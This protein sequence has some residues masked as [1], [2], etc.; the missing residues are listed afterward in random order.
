MTCNSKDRSWPA[1]WGRWSCSS[2]LRW[3]GLTWT[4][5]SRCGVLSTGE[6][7]LLEHVQ[8]RATKMTQGM[9]HLPYENR[10]RELGLFS[11]QKRRVQGGLRAAFQYLKGSCK[12]EG[13]RL[14]SRVC[15]DRA[16]GNT[17]RLKFREIL[18]WIKGRNVL[19]YG[20]WG[21]RSGC[22]ERWWMPH[23]WRNSGSG[24]TGLW[25]TW[26]CC[27]CPC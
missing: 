3:W 1:S 27:R 5:V 13:D 25:V 10:L 7:D 23:P 4:A 21:T 11:L 20:W 8:R 6:M 24:W 2:A 17:F 19:Q 18:D 22:P 14:F 12:K 26:L 15:C 16:W 9:E